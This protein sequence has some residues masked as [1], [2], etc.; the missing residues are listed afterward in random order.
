MPRPI[1]VTYTLH[2]T[3][4]PQREHLLDALTGIQAQLPLRNLH[5]KSSTRTALRT[6]QEV[7][8]RL[9]DLGELGS[10]REVGGSV[11]DGALVNICLVACD[12]SISLLL[13]LGVLR[14]A[15][16]CFLTISSSPC[17]DGERYCI[18][19]LMAAAF[20][21]FDTINV[22]RAIILMSRTA[23][24]TRTLPAPSSETGFLCFPRGGMSTPRS[25]SSST[26]QRREIRARTSLVGT[27][28]S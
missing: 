13:K 8:V 20:T 19:H 4:G 17:G 16:A 3:T 7:N 6:I 22:S 23:T 15:L 28:A 12:V 25:L 2:P 5:W 10:Q 11:M 27:K 14:T 21:F 24:Y 26:P 1:T 9:T 18:R